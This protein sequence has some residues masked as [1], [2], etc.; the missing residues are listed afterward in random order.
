MDYREMTTLA[1]DPVR[2]RAMAS[3]ILQLDPHDLS[4]G[5]HG[6]L[7]DL[8]HYDGAKPLSTRQLEALYALRERASRTSRAGHY[9]A[10]TLINAAWEARFDLLDGDAEEWLDM[11]RRR[12]PDVALARMEWR[13]LFGLCRRLD[14]VHQD[15]WIPL[16]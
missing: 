16:G 4:E 11:L 6:F 7:S 13:R 1:G 9:R 3:L 10:A 5:M 15:E 2:V 12:G 14:I 8:S